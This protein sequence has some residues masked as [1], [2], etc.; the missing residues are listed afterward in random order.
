MLDQDPGG[1]IGHPDPILSRIPDAESSNE[2]VVTG[3]AYDEARVAQGDARERSTEPINGDERAADRYLTGQN[4][5][6]CDIEHDHAVAAGDRI[7]QAA[8]AGVVEVRHADHGAR[9]AAARRR[10][11]EALGAGRRRTRDE[12]HANGQ[13]HH[14]RTY[15]AHADP[16]GGPRERGDHTTLGHSRYW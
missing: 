10:R 16:S 15:S 13:D 12:G 5:A 3:T 6:A 9:G 2:D 8:R 7:A 4:D 11:V 1:R 14:S